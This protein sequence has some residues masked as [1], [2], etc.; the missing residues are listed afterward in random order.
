MSHHHD[1]D[2]DDDDCYYAISQV[3]NLHFLLADVLIDS[4][5][6]LIDII[7]EE[8]MRRVETPRKNFCTRE[9]SIN[10]KIK[11]GNL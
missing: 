10:N 2:D 11:L 9:F 6:C 8:C 7:I 3:L 4:S 1:D 5:K